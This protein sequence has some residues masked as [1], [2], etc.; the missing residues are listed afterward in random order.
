MQKGKV[1]MVFPGGNTCLG[2]YSFYDNIIDDNAAHIFVLKGGPGVGKSTF[3][4]RI[5]ADLLELGFDLEYHWCS[6]D[7][8]SLDAVVV[9]ALNVALLDGTAPHVV[10]PRYPG[11]VDEI[12]NLG[13][14]WDQAKLKTCKQEIIALSKKVRRH[15]ASAYRS[16]RMARVARDEEE[17]FREEGVKFQEFHHLVGNLFR[18]I[19]GQEIA[20]GK[21]TPRERHLFAWAL[22]PQGIVHHLPTVLCNITSL[23]VIQGDPGS[24][25]ESIFLEL[26]GFAYRSG[27]AVEV[28][29]CAFNPALID[30][31]VLPDRQTAVLNLFP[32]LSFD[33]A[34]L[35]D[36]KNHEI[37]DCN[38]CL[39]ATVLKDYE[40]EMSE[41]RELFRGCFD[42]AMHYLQEESRVHGEM[43]RYYLEAMDFEGV[44]RKRQ[45]VLDRILEYARK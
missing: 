32:E 1:K 11:A 22:T 39:D 21:G 19:F 8:E 13:E 42:R 29:H 34:T 31:I 40:K 38:T 30:L 12:V 27:A 5:G 16:L 23:Y 6:S 14:Y 35:P 20:W 33:P 4:K 10:D 9:P 24:G 25:K 17:C 28:Y 43:E 45:E 26:A 15:F 41:A 7:S 18:Q 36:L 37:T 2:F 44:E 3:M